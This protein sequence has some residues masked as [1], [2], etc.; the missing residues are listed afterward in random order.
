[1]FSVAPNPV[2]ETAVIKCDEVMTYLTVLNAEMKPVY[3]NQPMQR[4][5]SVDMDK[6]PAGVYII[7]VTTMKDQF[8]QRIVR[9]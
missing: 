1:M 5:W 8:A 3:T 4:Q 6:F 9:M 2:M 7:S